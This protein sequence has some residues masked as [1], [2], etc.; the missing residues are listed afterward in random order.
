[1]ATVGE[2]KAQ[3]SHATMKAGEGY[4][5]LETAREAIGAAIETFHEAFEAAAVAADGTQDDT[6]NSAVARFVSA[7]ASARA[8]IDTLD[9]A[10]SAAMAGNDLAE[11]YMGM[12][13]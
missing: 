3:L 11:E 1:M 8:L 7:E 6:I 2:V 4:A 13:G 5:S 9:E 10:Q 12:L